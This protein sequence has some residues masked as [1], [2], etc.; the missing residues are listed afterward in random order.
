MGTNNYRNLE[1][2]IEYSDLLVNELANHANKNERIA[3]F[4]DIA[5]FILLTEICELGKTMKVLYD[6]K[7]T[8]GIDSIL[9][10][11][12]ERYFYL[13]HIIKSE[14][15]AKAFVLHFEIEKLINFDLYYNNLETSNLL[16]QELN[17]TREDI[18]SKIQDLN[19]EYL[20]DTYCN[21]IIEEYIS[22]FKYAI[23][24]NPKK[25]KW[26]NFD[27]ETYNLRDLSKS[28]DLLFEYNFHYKLFSREVHSSSVSDFF[29]HSKELNILG[30]LATYI[31][32][33]DS[34]SFCTGYLDKSI[35][36]V[37][38]KYKT[39]Q[40]LSKHYNNSLRSNHD[41][42]KEVMS[43]LAKKREKIKGW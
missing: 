38:S 20:D 22:C 13:A 37:L 35:R 16:C 29:K 8:Y 36:T 28:L 14:D 43:L 34:L 5:V 11:M 2:S 6:N 12:I 23:I 42:T 15:N 33:D 25:M 18:L 27:G 41:Y 40:D 9:R 21:K 17:H 26:Y 4:T 3:D 30:T 7:S 39:F 24:K 31:P 32:N 1:I 10:L 19:P